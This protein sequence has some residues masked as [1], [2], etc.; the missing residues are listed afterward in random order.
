MKSQIAVSNCTVFYVKVSL[1]V[2]L[3]LHCQVM[4]DL[5]VRQQ[6]LLPLIDVVDKLSLPPVTVENVEQDR[7]STRLN[8]SHVRTS[9]MPSSA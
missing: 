8:S 3:P 6:L 4:R 2:V 1:V 9:R 5:E 7:K